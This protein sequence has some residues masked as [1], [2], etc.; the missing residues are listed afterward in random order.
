MGDGHIWNDSNVRLMCILHVT[1]TSSFIFNIVFV[2]WWQGCDYSTKHS[3]QGTPDHVKLIF[4]F[5]V[6]FTRSFVSN[7]VFCIG[8][9]GATTKHSPEAGGS[10]YLQATDGNDTEEQSQQSVGLLTLE[11]QEINGSK[12]VNTTNGNGIGDGYVMKDKKEP[13]VWGP[14]GL[15]A[16]PHVKMVIFLVCVVQVR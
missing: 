5:Q 3:P 12:T 2:Q 1:F 11:L 7:I 13:G 14:D 4:I 8:G 10:A 15:L 16:A 6:T 9:R